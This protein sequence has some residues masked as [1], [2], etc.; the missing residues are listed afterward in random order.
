MADAPKTCRACGDEKPLDA[1]PR[2]GPGR[3]R[4]D[5]KACRNAAKRA[6]HAERMGDPAYVEAKRA[7]R[8]RHNATDKRR[9]KQA[10]YKADPGYRDRQAAAQAAR[11]AAPDYV[12][13]DRPPLEVERKQQAARRARNL[14]R[15][16]ARERERAHRRR[17]RKHG[18]G[19]A[20][21]V[22]D[23]EWAAILAEWDHRC[24]Y[25][26]EIPEP[27]KALTQDHVVPLSKGGPHDPLNVAPSCS[28]CNL[29]KYNR[30]PAGARQRLDAG[31]SALTPDR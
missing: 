12:R 7:N 13:T 8:A 1:F 3:V 17:A 28:A 29:H 10:E 4:P 15:Y 19:G 20:G 11:R 27:G 14:E 30:E 18:N 25:C 23:E 16:R 24:A 21:I 2:N 22:T 5:C 26:N 6:R 31:L 9:A